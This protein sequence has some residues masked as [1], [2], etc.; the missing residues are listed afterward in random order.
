MGIQK[1]ILL[2]SRIH[3]LQINYSVP[4]KLQ[5]GVIQKKDKQTLKEP[6]THLRFR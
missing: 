1:F 3:Y 6:A 5:H 4:S 2:S